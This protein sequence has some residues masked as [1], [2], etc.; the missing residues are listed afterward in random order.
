MGST[1]HTADPGAYAS[2][3]VAGLVTALAT[4]L[5][6]VPFFLFEEVGDRWNVLLWG[7]PPASWSPRRCS[8][9]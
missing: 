3:F 9:S 1:T 2:V 4:G 6:A 5:G 7:S 8:A